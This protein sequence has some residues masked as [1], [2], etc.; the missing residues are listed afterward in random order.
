MEM[1]RMIKT[2]VYAKP[3]SF[4]EVLEE[5]MRHKASETGTRNILWVVGC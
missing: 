2:T 5:T 3:M 1:M 4:T